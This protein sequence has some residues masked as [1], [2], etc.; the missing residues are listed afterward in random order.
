MSITVNWTSLFSFAGRNKQFWDICTEPVNILWRFI[1][2]ILAF[3]WINQRSIENPN[4]HSRFGWT[5]VQSWRKQKWKP[6]RRLWAYQ[7][8][9]K[10]TVTLAASMNGQLNFCLVSHRETTA[11]D[12]HGNVKLSQQTPSCTE[13]VWFYLKICIEALDNVSWLMLTVSP[14]S[15]NNRGRRTDSHQLSPAQSTRCRSRVSISRRWVSRPGGSAAEKRLLA[16]IVIIK[17]S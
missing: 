14:V 16:V 17:H 15:V 6:T 10:L 13:S 12:W 4:I 9:G 2:K 5:V 1:N 7:L 8:V 11:N 3:Q